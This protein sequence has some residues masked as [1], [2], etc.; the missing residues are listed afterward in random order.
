MTKGM[1]LN[2]K[3]SKEGTKQA[4]M[5]S[6]NQYVDPYLNIYIQFKQQNHF[7]YY[8][9]QKEYKSQGSKGIRQWPIN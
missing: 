6:V 1:D 3:P 7:K 2:P 9:F 8:K 5:N 4:T